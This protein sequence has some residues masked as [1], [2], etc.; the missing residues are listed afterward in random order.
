MAKAILSKLENAFDNLYLTASCV[1]PYDFNGDGYIDLFIGGR[2]VPW[3][4]GEM[5]RSYLLQNDETG[6]FIDVTANYV[7]R[8]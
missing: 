2:A 7:Q 1:A 3:E 5:P 8:T 4:Y 6:K